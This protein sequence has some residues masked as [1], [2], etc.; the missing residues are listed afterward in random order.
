MGSRSVRDLSAQERRR[1]SLAARTLRATVFGCVVLGMTALLI[2]LGF[3]G[4]SL[5]RQYI[6]HAFDTANHAEVSVTHAADARA[7]AKQVMDIYRGLGEDQRRKVNTDEYRALFSDIDTQPGSDY[8]VL[9]HVLSAFNRSREI[10]YVYL[11]MYDEAT[12]SLVYIVDPSENGLYPGDWEPVSEKGMRKFLDWDGRGILYDIDHPD[13][14]GWMC[15]VGVP[16]RSV[17]DDSILLFV[18]ADVTLHSVLAGM[19]MLATQLGVALLAL[20]A[21]IAFLMMRRFRKNIIAPINAI[22]AAAEGYASDKRC[23]VTETKRF[24]GLDIH[25]CDELENLSLVMADMERSLA[26]HEADLMRVTAEK[27]RFDTELSLAARIQASMLPHVFPPF[28]D[29]AEFDLCAVM[30]PAREVGGDFYDFFLIDDDHLGLVIAD[31]SGKGVPAA[32]FMMASKIILQ[33]CAMLGRSPAEILTKTNE[34]IC[35]NNPVEMFVTVWLG[36]LEISTGRLTAANA[37]HEYPVL[38]R[39]GGGYELYRDRHG[40]VI[41]AMPGARYQAYELQLMPGDRLF[42]Y[43]DGVPEAMNAEG[44]LFDTARMVKALNAQPEA[45]PEA[46]LHNVRRAVDDFVGDA[47]QFDDMTMLCLE[48]RGKGV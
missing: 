30:D 40:I 41:G 45:G 37:G 38:K 23:H 15:T 42:T 12:C 22:A 33:S 28:P 25:T 32:L 26:G 48:Y 16:I 8:A 20:T 14:Y 39:A 17:E 36:I 19:K 9:A 31:V 27:E 29:R 3:Y 2:G 43:T 35:S 18:L 4:A 47:E 34:A 46:L 13:K 21:L 11:A 5:S 6:R 7:L 44:R 24:A 10:D 1:H